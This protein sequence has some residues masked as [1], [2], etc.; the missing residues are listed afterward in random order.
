MCAVFLD[1]NKAFDV[2]HKVLLHNLMY[3]GIRDK[4]KSFLELI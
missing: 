2:N 4:Q 1:L 3:Y